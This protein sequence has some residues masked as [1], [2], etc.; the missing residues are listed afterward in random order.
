[1]ME[2]FQKFSE[3]ELFNADRQ[4]EMDGLIERFNQLGSVAAGVGD[5]IS[6]AFTQGFADIIT[7]TS[8]R[9]G[10][11]RQH[12]REHWSILHEAGSADHC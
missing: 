2:E 10:C 11:S 12:V 4:A 9:S 8:L 1:M 7:G 6:T 3:T 5:A